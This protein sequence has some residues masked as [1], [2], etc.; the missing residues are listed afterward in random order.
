MNVYR[1]LDNLPLFKNPVITIGTF[2]GVHLGHALI[3]DRL[4]KKAKEV[5]GESIIITFEPHPR[6]VL[7][8]QNKEVKLLCTLDEKLEALRTM[9]IDHVVVA[10]FTNIQ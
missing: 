7:S 8:A 3:I 6:L 5:N 1:G 2:D 4:K 9:G 10:P